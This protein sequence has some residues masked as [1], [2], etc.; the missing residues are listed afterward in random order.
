MKLGFIHRNTVC[1][2]ISCI[3]GALAGNVAAQT[4][5][6]FADFTTSKGNFSCQ[7]DY[8]NAPKAVANF[9]SLATGSRS[10][11]DLPTG[12]ARTNAF[13]DGLKFHRVI[14]GFMVQGGS[15]KGDGS[16]GP[17]YAFRDEFSAAL[18]FDRF[19]RLAMANSGKDSNGSQFF[20]TVAP[21]AWLNDV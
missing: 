18:R 19:G 20:I 12:R 9:I 11:L 14:A 13:Y 6:I 8:T 5:G 21:T 7:L 17:G 4:N 16:D 15:P 1:L 3:F 10:W 2:V